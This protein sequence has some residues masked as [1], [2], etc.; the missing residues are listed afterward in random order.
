MPLANPGD[1][2]LSRRGEVALPDESHPDRPEITIGP[3][4]ARNISSSIRRSAQEMPTDIRTQTALN[5][6]LVYSLLGMTENEIAHA[7]NTSLDNIRELRKLPAYQETFEMLFAEILSVNSSSIQAKISS[8]ATEAVE[9]VMSLA[10][11]AKKEIVK[12]KANQ[13]VLDRAGLHP[14][15]LYGKN[16]VDD[17]IGSLKIVIQDGEDKNVS[18]DIDMKGK[19]R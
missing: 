14:E 3:P 15:T 4:N 6:V 10:R 11:D 9:N 1:P 13:D 7:T 18:V 19:R 12:L 8:F 17:G 5:V 16:A 2:Y